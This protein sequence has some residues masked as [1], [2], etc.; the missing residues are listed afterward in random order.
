MLKII[1]MLSSNY[2]ANNMSSKQSCIT[3][4]A[5][6]EAVVPAVSSCGRTCLRRRAPVVPNDKQI[7]NL[8]ANI[9]NYALTQIIKVFA[10]GVWGRCLF[11][12]AP[13][14]VKANKSA[15]MY[16]PVPP[17]CACNSRQAGSPR[18]S[19]RAP[20]RRRV[21]TSRA[22]GRN[23]TASPARLSPRGSARP[24]RDPS[25]TPNRSRDGRRC[26][27]SACRLRSRACHIHRPAIRISIRFCALL[28]Q[29]QKLVHCVGQPAAEFAD[30]HRAFVS[31]IFA[32]TR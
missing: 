21:R 25:A 10:V 30:Q 15:L 26:G 11:Q 9:N 28:G 4:A 1:I 6:W 3:Q 13:P 23:P 12:K 20:S 16:S 24:C 19:A 5:G 22:G 8:R 18:I 31:D 17:D 7:Y 29:A 27:C 32:L 2:I 14:P